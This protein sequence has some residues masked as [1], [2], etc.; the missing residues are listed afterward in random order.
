MVGPA[1]SG[2]TTIASQVAQAL[3]LDFYCYGAISQA[4]EFLGYYD[5]NGKYVETDFYRAF[6]H[7]GLVLMDEMD[8]STPMHCWLSTLRWLTISHRFP[9]VS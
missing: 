4:F 2:K 9:V 8:A 5:A 1:G 3:G 7:G 6:K